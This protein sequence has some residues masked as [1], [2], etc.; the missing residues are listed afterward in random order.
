TVS[1]LLA[2]F[3]ADAAL[4]L[5]PW[6]CI[7]GRVFSLDRPSR[8]SG[9]L[10]VAAAA[11]RGLTPSP[12]PFHGEGSYG[13]GQGATLFARLPSTLYPLPFTLNPPPTPCRRGCW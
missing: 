7:A 2:P 10:L 1:T 12:S 6:G 8:E 9:A 11:A 4:R 5:L 13:A 3:A